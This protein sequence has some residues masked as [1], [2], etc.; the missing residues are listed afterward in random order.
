MDRNVLGH[1]V[2][3]VLILLVLVSSFSG[4]LSSSGY[5]HSSQDKF[6]YIHNN[7]E[8]N[9]STVYS[10]DLQFKQSGVF[11]LSSYWASVNVISV[12]NNVVYIGGENHQKTAVFMVY[13]V[14]DGT[15]V[16]YSD[17]IP[18]S[19]YSINSIC[20]GDGIVLL[21]GNSS[22]GG[23]LEEYNTISATFTDL[24]SDLGGAFNVGLNTIAFGADSFLIGGASSGNTPLYIFYPSNN[25]LLSVSNYIPYYF[26]SNH[27]VWDG[28]GFLMDGGKAGSGSEPG[29]PPALGIFYPGNY[30]FRDLSSYA[31]SYLGV[32]GNSV[33][34]DKNVIFQASNSSNGNPIITSLNL[35][36][37]SFDNLQHLFPQGLNPYILGNNSQGFYIGGT[38]TS[39]PLFFSFFNVSVD[40]YVNLTGDITGDAKSLIAFGNSQNSL[41]LILENFED[42][43]FIENLDLDQNGVVFHSSSLISGYEWGVRLYNSTASLWKNS[44]SSHIIFSDIANGTYHFSII[45]FQNF[46]SATPVYGI[47]TYNGTSIEETIDF[48][49]IPVA[50]VKISISNN[51]S[52]PT[53]KGFQE[54]LK[55]NW[56]NFSQF[57]NN[58]ASNVRFFSSI[59]FQEASELYGWIQNNDSSIST[60]SDVWVNMGNNTVPADG[61]DSIYM[62]FFSKN[63]TW[64]IHWGTPE[65]FDNGQ[66]VFA[67]YGNFSESLRGWIPKEFIGGYLPSPSPNGLEL[68][69]NEMH[70]GAYAVSPSNLSLN[71]IL[72]QSMWN[73]NG[74]ADGYSISVFGNSTVYD[75]G[76]G[77][78]PGWEGGI[79]NHYEFYQSG[80]GTDP[81]GDPNTNS[82]FILNGNNSGNLIVS[83]S[84]LGSGNN[85]VFSYL[86]LTDNSTGWYAESGWTNPTI[87]FGLSDFNDYSSRNMNSTSIQSIVSG[88]P[89]HRGNLMVSGGTGGA[90]AYI[91]LKWLVA[92][93]LP[94]NG[95]MPGAIYHT[96]TNVSHITYNITYKEVGLPSDSEWSIKLSNED[97]YSSNS[98]SI[99]VSV[100][101]G[102]YFYYPLSDN[103]SWVAIGGYVVVNGTAL[104]ITVTFSRAY[105][106]TFYQSTLP[107]NIDWFVNVTGKPS[108]GTL[109]NS[110]YDIYLGNGTY[111][112]QISDNNK[113]YRLL[114]VIDE[115]VVNGSNENIQLSF[116]PV[117]YYISF[118]E[119]GLPNGLTWFLNISDGQDIKS[120]SAIF[121]IQLTNGTY[122]YT[123]T[124]TN[125]TWSPQSGAFQ[126]NGRNITINIIFEEVTYP[127]KIGESNLPQGLIWYFN[128]SDGQ[129]YNTSNSYLYISL[130]NGSYTYYVSSESQNWGAVGGNFTV[131]GN[132]VGLSISFVE[133][134]QIVF[135]ETGLPANTPWYLN[136]LG[137]YS[138]GPI[139]SEYVT[140]KIPLGVY[141]YTAL[142]GNNKYAPLLGGITQDKGQVDVTGDTTI[143]I[144]F[145]PIQNQGVNML[146]FLAPAGGLIMA[147]SLLIY[148][149]SIKR[150]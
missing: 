61:T 92:R 62:V 52:I 38:S 19:F 60:S 59:P 123:A 136:I 65:K 148:L 56:S 45:Y 142:S 111:T 35:S 128:L 16:N 22:S 101:N 21:G 66:Y 8:S 86:M 71:P 25:T 130:P 28:S 119:S 3:L 31:P 69:N 80:H 42:R 13:N 139:Y 40:K 144:Q 7:S 110:S 30:S 44:T 82:I 132:A 83:N 68:I 46:E 100:F 23:V 103:L 117:Y 14:T 84:F 145:V 116:V 53:V 76:G 75:G 97:T 133:T 72:I 47:I 98:T 104:T 147:L 74:N 126:V 34:F 118:N 96:L 5:S 113:T 95:V 39:L 64:G 70:E 108:S 120:V 43:F 121:S 24:T 85:T 150:G 112:V 4:N 124:P 17:E 99:I 57:L 131:S 93:Y 49:P 12:H 15:I 54:M 55:I 29:T 138:S 89:L 129:S 27:I 125:K 141:F 140:V 18:S 58:N 50:Y 67:A 51:Q 9:L 94:P 73:Y 135:K 90:S 41:F 122:T 107:S 115:F 33:Y 149:R 88:F 6:Q 37:G 106:V 146:Y 137:V 1:F 77:F 109:Y 10:T 48:H 63:I 81:S 11:N 87:P 102:S 134:F 143:L 79:T 78:T 36:N 127:V 105:M 91:Y 32:V 20:Y 114:P 2:I 26:A